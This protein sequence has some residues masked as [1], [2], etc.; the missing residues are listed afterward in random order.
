[1][2][3]ETVR[4][5][6]SYYMLVKGSLGLIGVLLFLTS[7]FSSSR[8]SVLSYVSFLFGDLG[9]FRAT[10]LIPVVLAIFAF[11]AF[12]AIKK[13]LGYAQLLIVIVLIPD[14]LSF[15]I[16]TV[17]SLVM[18]ALTI[19]PYA[20]FK[21][22]A[23]T[24]MPY[25]VVGGVMLTFSVVAILMVSGAANNFMQDVGVSAYPQ[26]V[27]VLDASLVNQTGMVD[28]IIQLDTPPASMQSVE[29]QSV[30]IQDVETMGGVVTD[31]TYMNINSVLTKIDAGSLAALSANP[32]V[33]RIV[34]N[35][36]VMFTPQE[37][38]G[39]ENQNVQLLDNSYQLLDVEKLWADGITGKN[40]VV[41]VV[42]TGINS[43]L[44]IF[45]RDG[46]SIVID[47]LQ[48]YG[49]YVFWHGTAVAS[50]IASQ[51][52]ERKGIA[53]GV[54][55]LNVEVFQPNGGATYW[56]ILKGWDYVSKWKADHD[57]VV[58]CCNSLGA[59]P[60]AVSCGGWKSPSILDDAAN[61]MVLIHN[62]PMVVAAGN[63][64]G[65]GP[66]A[67][68]PLKINSPGQAQ[69]V[70]TVG[71]VDDSGLLATFS[72]RGGTEDGKPKPDV[73][74]PG[75]NVNM[76]N[77]KG[78]KYT[79]SGTSFSTPLV[80]GVV[81]LIAQQHPDFS[82]TQLQ[83]AI[84][85]S[86][87]STIAPHKTTYDTDYGRGLVDAANALAVADGQKPAKS[88]DY[89]LLMFPFLGIFILLYPEIK[90]FRL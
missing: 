64:A 17:L 70:L 59:H 90:K 38:V 81:A 71:A 18:I 27:Q 53:P 49:E 57:R 88:Q 56:D 80:T 50:C 7:N 61:E 77:D 41:A 13:D 58:I 6:L 51:D 1:M 72:C 68:W 48:L 25:R 10:M 82:A 39:Y 79:S 36:Q 35:K 3:T 62:I 31:S 75:V 28:V 9:L 4:K 20:E 29:I 32:I 87:D 15:P 16:G 40:I 85:M 67:Q 69:Y 44:P 54:D 14:I 78:E 42:D 5:T 43:K 83:D 76:F 74:A 24:D 65:I 26:D 46:K 23:K 52:S 30:F 8:T 86:A 47:S 89:T 63:K 45:Q 22:M 21:P 33:K 12:Y 73:V 34:P 66:F 37:A 84:K 19:L 55:L 11:L 60:M 2:K